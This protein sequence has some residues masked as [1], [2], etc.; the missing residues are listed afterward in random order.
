MM[1]NCSHPFNAVR[2]FEANSWNDS[3]QFEDT[4]KIIKENSGLYLKA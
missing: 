4:L 2:A 3:K 1:R